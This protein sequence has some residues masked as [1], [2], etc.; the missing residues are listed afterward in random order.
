[1]SYIKVSKSNSTIYTG[2]QLEVVEPRLCFKI[3][4][5]LYIQKNS[6]DGTRKRPGKTDRQINRKYNYVYTRIH[7]LE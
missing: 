1:M 4:S 7:N 5:E 2:F 6:Y 3:Y